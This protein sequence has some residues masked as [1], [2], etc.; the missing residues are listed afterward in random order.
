MQGCMIGRRAFLAGMISS[1][2]APLRASAALQLMPAWAAYFE[3]IGTRGVVCL[4]KP[5]GSIATSDVARTKKGYLPASTFKIANALIAMDLG[6]VTGADET[7][8][9]DGEVHS[10]GEK[11]IDAWNRDQSLREAFAN[12]TIWVFQEIARRIGKER[13]APQVSALHYGN[14]D[15]TGAPIDRFWLEGNLRISAAQQ[16]DV[17]DR[18][19]RGELPLSRQAIDM[20]RKIMLIEQGS[21]GTLYGKTGWTTVQNI[22]W[23]VGVIESRGAI[24]PFALNMDMPTIDLAKQRIAIVKSVAAD[25]GIF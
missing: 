12:S 4:R 25:L 2:S 13:M 15:I 17:L 18:L 3:K 5:D 11:P 10:L 21:K 8:K 9:W 22:G 19:W 16:I 14:A 6:V 20:T 23:F 1:M 24:H 7:F